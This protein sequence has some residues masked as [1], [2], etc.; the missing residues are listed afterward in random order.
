MENKVVFYT[1]PSCTSCRKA[2]AWLSEQGVSFE[3]R[4]LYKEPPTSEELMNII[5]KT[6]NGTEEILSTRSQYFKNLDIDIEN[7]KV[8]E[9]LEFLSREPKLLKRPI[10]TNGENIIIGYNKIALEENFAS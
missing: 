7:M 1:Y 4:H 2:K 6:H 8:S 9:F 5:K 10:L 3:E